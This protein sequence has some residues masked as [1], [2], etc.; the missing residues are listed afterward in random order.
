MPR[1][2]KFTILTVSG[3]GLF[4]FDTLRSDECHPVNTES[5]NA[6]GLKV[7]DLR[8]RESRRTVRLASLRP[9]APTIGRWES[10]GWKVLSH[11]AYGPRSP[12]DVDAAVAAERAGEAAIS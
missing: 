7:H 4:P 12:D 3:N 1:T 6:I 2:R 9:T 10:F 11:D 5:A 8:A